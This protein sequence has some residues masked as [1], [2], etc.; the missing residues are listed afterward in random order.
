ML[1]RTGN[2]DIDPGKVPGQ[3]WIGWLLHPAHPYGG[4]AEVNQLQA[5]LVARCSPNSSTS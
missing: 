2:I 3:R 5:A 4:P 1:P